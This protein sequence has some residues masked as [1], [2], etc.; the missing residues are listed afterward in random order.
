[1]TK[2][3][4]A[5]FFDR[6]GYA[7]PLAVAVVI[8][9]LMLTLVIAEWLRLFV[10][11]SG[12]K[13]AFE[14][15]IISVVTENYNE[16][17]HCVR[18]GYAGGYEPVGGG[19]YASVDYGDVRG[20]LGNLLGMR[21][22]GDVLVKETD[23]KTEFSISEVVVSVNNVGIRSRGEFSAEGKLHLVIP[24]WFNGR[25]VFSVP[26]DLKVKARMREKF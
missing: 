3:V 15:A 21:A 4:K 7:Y 1:M 26:L 12:V 11:A 17:Y 14:E 25:V 2:K 6:S 20:R 18:E 23:G 10:I 13:D 19:F 22:D 5:L 8:A 24:V 9:L 16:T